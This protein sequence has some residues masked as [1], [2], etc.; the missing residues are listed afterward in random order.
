MRW[1]GFLDV[2]AALG[3]GLAQMRDR[4]LALGVRRARH[5][6]KADRPGK[7]ASVAELLLDA[8]QLVVLRHAIRARRRPGLDLPAT[9]GHRE[10]GDS[11]HVLGLP[12]RSSL[13]RVSRTA[14]PHGRASRRSPGDR[15]PAAAPAPSAALPVRRRRNQARPGRRLDAGRPRHGPAPARRP[16]PLGPRPDGDGRVDGGGKVRKIV[17]A[18][19]RAMVAQ[20]RVDG[21]P[22]RIRSAYRSEARQADVFE[23]WARQAGRTKAL[24]V[25]ARPGHSEHQLGTTIDFARSSAPPWDGNFGATP[26]GPLARAERGRFR[27]RDE[28]P[29]GRIQG[30]VLR[31]RAVAF[32]M[33][34]AGSRSFGRRIRS[35]PPRVA[36][37]RAAGHHR[38]LSF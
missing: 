26:N 8:Q 22:L 7:L 9:G 33:G 16:R 21:I 6:R 4:G 32:P 3:H 35:H 25:S 29:E 2:E 27:V 14:R 31:G 34:R 24:R 1:T 37:A 23:D 36:V 28:L 19:L 17:M 30:H 12:E 38:R 10:I 11:C 20:A 15:N 18:D 13:S 5:E